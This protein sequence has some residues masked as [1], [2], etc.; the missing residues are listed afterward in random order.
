MSRFFSR[1]RRRIPVLNTAALP[2]LIFTMLFFFMIVTHMDESPSVEVDLP[3]DAPLEVFDRNLSDYTIYIG[4]PL[5]A[6][7]QLS[8]SLQ[9]NQSRVSLSE[10]EDEL[11]MLGRSLSA[12]ERSELVVTLKADA[13][14]EMRVLEHIKQLLRQSGITKIRYAAEEPD[15]KQE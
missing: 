1:S 10:L 11:Q 9:L 2:D 14:T 6:D 4:K 15:E 7:N 3:E 8:V 12:A 13:E 5:Q